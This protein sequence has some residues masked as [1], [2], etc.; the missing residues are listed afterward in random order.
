LFSGKVAEIDIRVWGN[1][2]LQRLRHPSNLPH[3]G[4]S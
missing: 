1:F 3:A 4:P 2:R